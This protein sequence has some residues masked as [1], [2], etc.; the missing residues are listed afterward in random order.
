MLQPYLP[1][2]DEMRDSVLRTAL[3]AAL[4]SSNSY[5]G[6]IAWFSASRC[7]ETAESILA[8]KIPMSKIPPLPL[9]SVFTYNESDVFAQLNSAKAKVLQEAALSI[10][11]ESLPEDQSKV[12]DVS[13]RQLQAIWNSA[14]FKVQ[15]REELRDLLASELKAL[16]TTR[17][18][19]FPLGEVTD[20][21]VP[22]S[23]RYLQG[24]E[25]DC[26]LLWERRCRLESQ[27]EQCRK[28]LD[29][30]D[31]LAEQMT[32]LLHK[33][34]ELTETAR[35]RS[36]QLRYLQRRLLKR[37]DEIITIHARADNEAIHANYSTTKA[38]SISSEER[39]KRLSQFAHKQ[40]EIAAL[41]S[42]VSTLGESVARRMLA[43]QQLE[44][45]VRIVEEQLTRLEQTHLEAKSLQMSHKN[46]LKRMNSALK[47]LQR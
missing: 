36:D 23:E 17:E 39:S 22:H 12:T 30:E 34:R 28:K 9:K 11:E 33:T 29:A 6:V 15:R 40:R 38:S 32:T 44:S 43:E 18:A 19:T 31:L 20:R 35:K 5:F 41:Q 14:R 42:D 8:V 27:L 16:E 25:F 26:D 3:L 2:F 21:P 46:S 10:H 47:A 24:S 45:K 13:G 4:V 1:S 37:H 7:S